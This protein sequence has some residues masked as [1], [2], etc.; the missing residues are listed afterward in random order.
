MPDAA[1]P[2]AFVTGASTGIGYELVKCCAENGFDLVVAAD[3]PEINDAARGFRAPGAAVTAVVADL[4][5]V[6]GVRKLLAA[7][8][9]VGRPVDALL[10]NAGRDRDRLLRA[11]RHAG[12]QDRSVEEG[13]SR[14]S[15]GPA[16]RP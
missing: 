3:E 4:A 10:A 12:H 8:A 1:R 11:R 2:L 5:T 13:R 9:K 14:R 15:R 7:V 16:S 6:E